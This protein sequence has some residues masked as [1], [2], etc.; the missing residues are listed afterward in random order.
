MGESLF[1]TKKRKAS[2]IVLEY[3]EPL[4]QGSPEQMQEARLL[5][6]LSVPIGIWNAMSYH[7]VG[8]KEYMRALFDCFEH[9]PSDKQTECDRLV[10]YWI[11]R[12]TKLF[13]DESWCIRDVKFKSTADGEKRFR[14][15]TCL[16]SEIEHLAP[17]DW[18]RIIR[19]GKSEQRVF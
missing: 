3:F 14:V 10:F 4:L 5:K 18:K 9:L 6:T 11:E 2:D 15:T 8:R 19:G 13:P 1:L 7:D 16:P 12:K 17:A